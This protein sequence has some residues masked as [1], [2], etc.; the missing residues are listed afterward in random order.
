[1]S[2]NEPELRNTLQLFEELI[3]ETPDE[4]Q[5]V[6]TYKKFIILLLK[7]RTTAVT[8]PI[9]EIMTVIKTKKPVIFSTLRRDYKNNIAMNVVTNIDVEY[10]EA[11]RKLN[12]LK[13]YLDITKRY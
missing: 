6:Q 7:T 9:S 5:Y 1:M 13:R 10:R 12:D 2:I 11:Y 3:M 4:R 8:L